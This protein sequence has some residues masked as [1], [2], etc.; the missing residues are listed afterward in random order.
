[1]LAPPSFDSLLVFRTPRTDWMTASIGDVR[2]IST[3]SAAAPGHETLTCSRGSSTVVR[4][5]SGSRVNATLPARSSAAQVAQTTAGRR[6]DQPIMGRT[7]CLTGGRTDGKTE[8]RK[9]RPRNLPSVRPSVLP[10]A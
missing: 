2:Y 3:S 5:A 7:G 8:G 10:P 1:M 4:E 9:R 6:A